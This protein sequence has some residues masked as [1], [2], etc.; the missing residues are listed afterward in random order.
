[1][2]RQLCLS[3][4]RVV[5]NRFRAIFG[6]LLGLI[7]LAPAFPGSASAAECTNTWVGPAEGTWPTAANWSAKKVPTSGDVVCI[8]AG[9]VIE[10]NGSQQAAVVSG[11]SEIRISGGATLALSGTEE[12]SS[13]RGLSLKGGAIDGPGAIH[14]TNLLSVSGEG[15]TMKGT[16][17]VVVDPGASGVLHP[18]G[19]MDLS[20]RTL[21]NEGT[22]TLQGGRITGMNGGVIENIGTFQANSEFGPPLRF[23][24][25]AAPMFRN[26]G[27]FEKTSGTGTTTIEFPFENKGAV[28]AKSGSMA[29][30]GGGSGIGT[31]S[32]TAS[33]GSQISL[34]GSGKTFA[35][36]A[37]TS[38]SG[39][40]S[41]SGTVIVSG[42]LQ[43][44]GR[45]VS[46]VSG[47]LI[48]KSL[49]AGTLTIPSITGSVT[50][51]SG[52]TSTVSTLSLKGGA[53]D[54]PGAIHVTNLLS[55]SGEGSTMKGTGSV[56]V[57]PGASGVLH[58]VGNMDL[59]VRTLIN[60]GTT[61]LQG[62][63][64]T[65]MNGGVIENIGTFQANSE[66]GPPLRFGGGAA[67]MFRNK[68][69][70][71]KTSG[72][73][74]TIVQIK[75]ENQGV[76]NQ[77]SGTLRIENPVTV[78]KTEQFGKRA[79]CGD[80]V[81]CATGNFYESQTD[82]A[83][84][85]LGVGLYLTRTYSAQAAAV[86]TAPGIFGY[87][88]M[89]SFGDRLAVEEGGAK[90]TLTRSD[91]STIPFVRVTGTTYDGPAWS[92]DELSG[93]PE[94]GYTLLRADQTQLDF[95]G[96]GR[97]ESI[98][99]REGNETGLTY[100]EAGRLKT[101]EDPAGR[102][103]TLTYNAGGQ[104]ESAKG[105]MGHVVKYAYE[106]KHLKSVTLPGE[107][108][109]RWQ[110]KY[111]GSHR[112]TTMTDG[113]GGKTTNEYD[114]SSRVKSQADPGGHTLT[115][116]Y[117]P[118]HTKITNKATGAITDQWFT[119]NNQPYSITRG[120]GTADATTETFSYNAAGQLAAI[121]D[122]NGHKTTYGYD[123][124]GNRKSEKD[125]EGNE[126]KWTYNATHD[127]ISMT[128]PGNETTT[129]ERD[130]DGSV[131]SI[132][133]PGP[134]EAIQT[135]TFD[136]DE[137]GQLESVTDPLE[138]TSTF[139]YNEQGDR[140]ASTDPEG[141]TRSFEYDE[142]SRL[143]AIVSPRGNAEGA[144]AAE[145]TTTIERDP[146]GRPLKVIDPFGHASE[147]VYDANGNLEKKTNANG[148]PTNYVYN[149]DNE[150]IKVEKPNGAI[151]ET[152]YDGAGNVTSQTDGNIKTTTYVR[153][154]LGQPVEVID[155]LSRKTIEAF[156]DA[157]N[158]KAVT[159]P[160]ERKTSYVYDKADR[161][162]EV[163][164]SDPA[165][166]DVEFEYD[167]NG[168]VT[169]ILDGT[170]ESTFEYDELG[171]LTESENGHGDVVGYGYDLGEQLTGVLYPNGK[172]VS[173]AF[174][175]VGRLESVTDWLGGT[176]TF[177]YDADSNLESIAFPAG[178]GNIDEY[179]YDP[180]GQMTGATFSKGMEAL[181][182]LSYVRGKIGQVEEEESTGLPGAKEI[183]YGY[184][185]NERLT[186][187]GEASFEY[188]AADNLTKAPGTTNAYDAASQ[189]E[190]GTGVSY[191]YDKIGQRVETAPASGPA[192][193][194]DY[195]QAGNLISIERPEE[196]EVPAIVQSLAYDG[197]G[198][199]ASKSSGLTTLQFNWDVSADLPLLLD[200]GE[201]SYVYGPYGLPI[202]QI[203]S[204]EPVYLH[205]DQLG[206]TRMLTD[207][208]GEVAGTFSFSPNGTL[209]ASTGS[210]TTPMG[211]AGQYTDPGSGLQYLRARFYDPATAQFITRDPMVGLTRA[212]YGYA[213]SNPLT[214]IDPSGKACVETY[215][216][217][218]YPNIVD[219]FVE[220]GQEV[221]ESPLTGTLGGIVC[222]FV[223][224]CTAVRALVGLGV[225][226]TISNL[227][228]AESD[229]C[230][231]FLPNQLEAMLSALAGS[232]P[233]AF[234]QFGLG[235]AGDSVGLTPL[236]ERVLELILEAPGI[237]L[238]IVRSGAGE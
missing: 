93:S 69:T 135:T 209:E 159:D 89:S 91:G 73:G 43:V 55:V 214:Y 188:D 15:S 25:G 201:N 187:A 194:Y 148:H 27:T 52:G 191:A 142:S 48:V 218:K 165:T 144:E 84:G 181:A 42:D 149:A 96:V 108:G 21:I 123:A 95:S 64:I 230:F 161:L 223:K 136:H 211:F 129:I 232:L 110:F 169:S 7:L 215:G 172:S 155:P 39:D 54:G 78:A 141:N 105:P 85:G 65:G 202:T 128:T 60:E 184:D 10:V 207:S 217:F 38:W 51:G 190:T 189:L 177:D 45:K 208:S 114:S 222:V 163:A 225:L 206:S 12:Q 140:I 145:F 2:R 67:P 58:P 180:T 182:S 175:Q 231:K 70:F 171:R 124:E 130:G 22:T 147:Y 168:N 14:V 109:A 139:E 103:I 40:F 57:D 235:R 154:A 153:N 24:G 107:A 160:A 92:Q 50:L 138:R 186:E 62:G 179:E 30:G 115:F 199:L 228:K 213:Q 204:E 26:K 164:Y 196:G 13:V 32:W 185:E 203:S 72:T 234:G 125:A 205:H 233:G 98:V 63:R 150:R 113:R 79:N 37:S 229:R 119:S 116:E 122:G 101:I 99:D 221:V 112:M 46:V 226:A 197:T 198:I 111:D 74:E 134:E 11:A 23:G 49:E 237:G 216:P 158:L 47:S 143:E 166:P 176:S 224:A 133:R 227:L 174:D 28:A 34:G 44:P 157:G 104:V 77:S 68:G 83:I 178:T 137:F 5:P 16:G 53:I 6:S 90:A 29:F 56:V 220:G 210:V 192:T 75:F 195:D 9:N 20:V 17:S 8:G 118:F 117:A 61:T 121:T 31:N 88:W 170:G 36:E 4:D 152:S 162:I 167:A 236:G 19:N 100:D 66:F 127:V 94:A 120:F 76:I 35:M 200:D 82:L 131:E 106:T 87:G 80:P 81:E 41:F 18:V 156:D 1:M 102:Q 238:D 33:E 183:S 173:R 97:F 71:E 59:S 146:Q 126:T 219:C 86:A 151:L 3:W 132:L 193:T 212:P